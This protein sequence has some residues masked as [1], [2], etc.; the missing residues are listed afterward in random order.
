MYI[1]LTIAAEELNQGLPKTNSAESDLISGRPDL[2][3]AAPT[4]WPVRCIIRSSHGINE[5]IVN[6]SV[7]TSPCLQI[8]FHPMSIR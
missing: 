5:S 3:S 1:A 6:S 2:W 4:T 8:S 7:R